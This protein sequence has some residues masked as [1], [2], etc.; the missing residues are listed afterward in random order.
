MLP[1]PSTAA[2][3]G[4]SCTPSRRTMLSI[5]TSIRCTD[6]SRSAPPTRQQPAA[7]AA[8]RPPSEFSASAAERSP[9]T[10]CELTRAPRS[11]ARH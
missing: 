10:L 11:Q 3:A 4:S 5:A 7:A 1:A 6:G 9:A 8:A 2:G